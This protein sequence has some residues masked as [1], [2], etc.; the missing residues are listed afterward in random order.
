MVNDVGLIREVNFM[1]SLLSQ[2]EQKEEQ[3]D[4]PVTDALMKR[5]REINMYKAYSQDVTLSTSP[6][7]NGIVNDS[8]QKRLLPFNCK[9]MLVIN[10]GL[11]ACNFLLDGDVKLQIPDF[12]VHERDLENAPLDAESDEE[13]MK[14]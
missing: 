2:Q 3:L 10:S 4:I 13:E 5:R 12:I 7:N 1:Q 14:L 8:F 9:M 11:R 6:R